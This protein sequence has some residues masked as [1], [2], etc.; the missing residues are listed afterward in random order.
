MLLL[1]R[2]ETMLEAIDDGWCSAI[3]RCD[4]MLRREL[5]GCIACVE[6]LDASSAETEIVP[7]VDELLDC[8]MQWTGNAPSPAIVHA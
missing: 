6:G 7:R 3:S 1:E 8:H 5:S 4:E 2:V